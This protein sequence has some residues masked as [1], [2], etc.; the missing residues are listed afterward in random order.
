MTVRDQAFRPWLS[1]GI[2]MLL[3]GSFFSIRTAS[4][5]HTAKHTQGTIISRNP[6][7]GIVPLLHHRRIQ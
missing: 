3:V 7:W 4:F 5:L 6:N 1:I 2:A